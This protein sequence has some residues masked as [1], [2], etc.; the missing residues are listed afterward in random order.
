MSRD[1]YSLS[2]EQTFTIRGTAKLLNVDSSRYGG[3]W[4]SIPHTHKHLELFYI[5]GGKGQFLIQ[6]QLYPVNVNN[7]VSAILQ[8]INQKMIAV[9]D[10]A[11]NLCNF[12]K[13]FN[14]C[15]FFK[16]LTFNFFNK[17]NPVGSIVFK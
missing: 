4:H 11:F 8:N 16:I 5:V 12:L 7:P 6:D 13:V 2:R 9:I 14:F 17:A 1:H 3:D 15:E 10:N